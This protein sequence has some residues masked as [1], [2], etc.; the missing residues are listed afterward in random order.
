MSLYRLRHMRGLRYEAFQDQERI[1]IEDRMLRLRKTSG[2]Y[3]DFGKSFHEVWSEAFINYT[4]ILVS[5]FGK[6]APSLYTVLTQF[7]GNI[8]QLSKSLQMA[9]GSTHNGNRS[10]YAHYCTTTIRYTEMGHPRGVS[11]PV[12]DA[13]DN[14]RHGNTIGYRQEE[15]IKVSAVAPYSQLSWRIEQPFGSV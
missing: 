6:K 11:G 12:L 10:S 3:K 7:Y 9:R 14:D 8:L 13:N 1:G 2:T 15:E 4:A 5:L